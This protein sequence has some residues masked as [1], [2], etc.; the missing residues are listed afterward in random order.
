MEKELLVSPGQDQQSERTS[1]GGWL[2]IETAPKD[3]T[4]VDLWMVAESGAS[5]RET[6][7]YFV[8]D[9]E[10]DIH[11]YSM[12]GE[13]Q[14]SAIRRDGW[15]APNHDYDGA[16]GWCDEPEWFN[17]HPRQ[18]KLIFTKPTHWMHLPPPPVNHE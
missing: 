5:W 3:G 16:D 15:W 11:R 1:V 10:N 17:E 4:I 6:D 8:T 12:A 18:R 2:P 14:R 9:R 13:I 7:A